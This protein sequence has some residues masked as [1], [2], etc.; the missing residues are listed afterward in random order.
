MNEMQS[1]MDEN[2][3]LLVPKTFTWLCEART[4]LVCNMENSLRAINPLVIPIKPCC[5]KQNVLLGNYK[6]REK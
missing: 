4:L 3:C 5:V 6:R 2:I 1:M